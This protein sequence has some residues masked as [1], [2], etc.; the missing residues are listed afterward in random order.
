MKAT[1]L[2]ELAH[3][4]DEDDTD[5]SNGSAAAASQE[6]AAA[7]ARSVD[8]APQARTGKSELLR[9]AWISPGVLMR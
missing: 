7:R 5:G 1:L 2:R 9:T 3:K 8:E 4:D 6:H